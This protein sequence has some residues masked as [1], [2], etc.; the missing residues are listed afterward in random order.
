MI[1]NV[2]FDIGKV[3]IEFD[4]KKFMHTLFTD[5]QV[6]EAVTQSIWNSG[7]WPEMDRGAMPEQE[8]LNHIYEESGEYRKEAEYTMEHFGECIGKQEYAIPWVKELK[9]MG[10]NVYFLSNYSDFL[11]RSN[12]DA[13]R[14]REYMDGGVFS[15]EEHLI[16]PDAAIY[17][18]LCEKYEL[19]PKETLFIDD[20]QANIDAA[21]AAGIKGIRFDGYEVTRPII[22]GYLKTGSEELLAT[23]PAQVVDD[24]IDWNA[25]KNITEGE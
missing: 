1:K 18:R 15:F 2:V 11:I 17:N 3:L 16:K 6:I 24:G 4:W 8:I 21:M 12:P 25:W 23:R 22:M 20:I 10:Y 19:V 9:A 14:F 7:W 5:E 13:L